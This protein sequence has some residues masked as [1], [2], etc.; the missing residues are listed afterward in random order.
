MINGTE[1][2]PVSM[3]IS[4][5]FPGTISDASSGLSV[6]ITSSPSGSTFSR[7]SYNGEF[8]TLTSTEFGSVDLFLPSDLSGEFEISAEALS[9]DLSS[10]R[11][12]TV[13]FS[14]QPVVDTPFINVVQ[15]DNCIESD[16]GRFTFTLASFLV[17]NDGSEVLTVIVSGM[18]NGTRL[19]VGQAN[20]QGDFIIR[21]VEQLT[22]IS[23]DIPYSDD[24][25]TVTVTVVA[26]ATESLT[27]SMSSTNATISISKCV[28]GRP[29]HTNSQLM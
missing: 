26:I 1:D 24:D 14:V 21:S 25:I 28:E 6:R 18:P 23:A 19:S 11:V 8:W 16:T 12:G 29:E 27:N 2:S 9:E 15:H 22:M 10:R 13:Q 7:G 17:D 20:E 4:A 3:Y 5:H